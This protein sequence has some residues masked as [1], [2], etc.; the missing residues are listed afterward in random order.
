MFACYIFH[1][2]YIHIY[3]SSDWLGYPYKSYQIP[4]MKEMERRI[5]IIHPVIIAIEIAQETLNKSRQ[6]SGKMW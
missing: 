1:M 3:M 4:A 2:Y 5:H 6:N